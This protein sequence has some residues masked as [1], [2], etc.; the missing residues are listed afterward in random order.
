M[1]D[2]TPTPLDL[3]ALTHQIRVA[4][5]LPNSMVRCGE[6]HTLKSV[7]VENDGHVALA[8]LARRTEAAETERDALAF[9]VDAAE[10]TMARLLARMTPLREA[11]RRYDASTRAHIDLPN[12]IIGTVRDFLAGE[13]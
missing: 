10:A 1:T 12:D 3:D 9:R 11:M 2:Q 5:S 13:A 8:N 7:Q 6:E 4:I